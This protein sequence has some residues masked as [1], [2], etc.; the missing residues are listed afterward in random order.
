MLTEIGNFI[1]CR[2]GEKIP[3]ADF[4]KTVATISRNKEGAVFICDKCYTK[5]KED[6]GK[7]H[8]RV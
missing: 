5:P 6:R 7:T 1:C 3:H 2:C 4:W 8:V